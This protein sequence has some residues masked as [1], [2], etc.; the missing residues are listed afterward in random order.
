MG[1]KALVNLTV[2][3]VIDFNIN[4]QDAKNLSG[5]SGISVLLALKDFAGTENEFAHSAIFSAEA[6]ERIETSE[7]RPPSGGSWQEYATNKKWATT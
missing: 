1:C 4:L 2:E 7:Q 3:G 5:E 6:W